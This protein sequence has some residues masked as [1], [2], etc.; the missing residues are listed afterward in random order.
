IPWRS[1]IRASAFLVPAGL[2][3]AVTSRSGTTASSAIA[4]SPSWASGATTAGPESGPAGAG[5]GFGRA[6]DGARINSLPQTCDPV[7]VGRQRPGPPRARF[8]RIP[9]ITFYCPPRWAAAARRAKKNLTFGIDNNSLRIYICLDDR[10]P[11]RAL[12]RRQ[13]R[14]LHLDAGAC[15]SLLKVPAVAHLIPY[16][17]TGKR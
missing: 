2:C 15:R 8:F 13:M 10:C 5:G 12:W 9:N 3:T 1:A 7:P 11:F 6:T 4:A 16:V 17:V 14:L